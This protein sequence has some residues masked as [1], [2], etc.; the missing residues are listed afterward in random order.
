VSLDT[1]HSEIRSWLD[2]RKI[3]PIEFKTLPLD[4]GAIAL[5]IRFRSEDEAYLF[6]RAFADAEMHSAQY[7]RERPAELRR[8]TA[9]ASA[10]APMPQRQ[11]ET[12]A[13]DYDQI[14][15]EL[16]DPRRREVKSL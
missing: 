5:N 12:T 14:A 8:Q 7:Y 16:N 6:E 11:L 15:D 1:P 10:S 2:S 3:E 4:G 9:A 13:G